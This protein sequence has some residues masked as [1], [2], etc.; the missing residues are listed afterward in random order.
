MDHTLVHP[1]GAIHRGHRERLAE[2]VHFHHVGDEFG[3]AADIDHAAHPGQRDQQRQQAQHLPG[4]AR[5]RHIPHMLVP[6]APRR[7]IRIG[8]L[9]FPASVSA[10]SAVCFASVVAPIIACAG[11]SEDERFHCPC[12]TC[13]AHAHA[14]AASSMP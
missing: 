5:G 3:L 1:L 13:H 6:G 9:P 4:L 14:H 8:P 11:L 2:F 10:I 7:Q 12:R